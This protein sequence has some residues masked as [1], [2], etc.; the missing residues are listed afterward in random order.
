MIGVAWAMTGLNLAADVTTEPDL[1]TVRNRFQAR[2]TPIRM[3]YDVAYRFL[4]FD[5]S[6][7]GRIA[8]T[9]TIG[10]YR[11]RVTQ[12]DMP[13]VLV[14]MRMDT[15]DRSKP[16]ARDR[17]SIHE[18]VTAVLTLPNLE[19]LVFGKEA[20]DHLNPLIGRKVVVHSVSCY[21]TESGG[22][23][24]SKRDLIDGTVSTNV[25]NP[26]ALLELSRNILPLTQFL[27]NR[28]RGQETGGEDGRLSVNADGEIVPLVM[29]TR[30]EKSPEFMDDQ[31]TSSLHVQ[32]KAEKPTRARVSAFEGWAV[33]MDE[34]ADRYG[35]DAVRQV[36]Q[37][38]PVK[39]VV[40]LA[41]EYELRLG[42]IRATLTNVCTAAPGG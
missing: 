26:Q 3:E 32:T 18:R 10:T 25:S 17:I 13:A 19:A 41:V 1:A 16:P 23:E 6:R 31:R 22:L 36:A 4:S 29:Q 40:P 24:F 15:P 42:S 9:T 30:L 38:A 21:D 5:V 28:Y 11:H 37:S 14:D 27:L 12:Q 35:D 8:L 2:E 34:L 39:S 7:L 20:D 33:P